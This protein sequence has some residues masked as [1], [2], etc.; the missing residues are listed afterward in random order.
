M[1]A[2]FKRIELNIAH[3]AIVAAGLLVLVFSGQAH[4]QPAPA[5]QD[6]AKLRASVERF[7]GAPARIDAQLVVARCPSPALSWARADVVRADCAD[8]VWTLYVPVAAAP[9]SAA[10]AARAKPAIRRGERVSV[11][12]GGPGFVIIMDAEAE[13]D[14]DGSKIALKTATGRRF[15]GRIA[16][17]GKVVLARP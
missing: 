4:A 16:D 12:A 2:K 11:E 10:P 1:R 3:L 9:A 17:G 5:L 15:T 6:V 7:A 8:P 14:A 13:R